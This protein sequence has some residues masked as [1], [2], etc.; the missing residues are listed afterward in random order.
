MRPVRS[1]EEARERGSKG[2]SSPKR[3]KT[4]E[5]QRLMKKLLLSEPALNAN[6]KDSLKRIGVDVD[7]DEELTTNAAILSATI[8][9]KAFSGDPE[10]IRMAFE[11][12]G[13]CITAKDITDRAKLEIEREKLRLL[14]EQG[15]TE[16]DAR[17]VIVIRKSD[18]DTV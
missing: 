3:K 14:S 8:L 7:G 1:K 16:A 13:Q 18:G 5:T 12:S 9:Q 6:T 10:F 2:G 17:P 15:I 11:M 4:L